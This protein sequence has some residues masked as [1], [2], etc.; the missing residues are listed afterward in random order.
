M[1]RVVIIPVYN[2]EKSLPFVLKDLLKLKLDEI[3]VVDNASSDESKKIILEHHVSYLYESR[4]GYGSACLKG[5]DYVYSKYQEDIS[6]GFIDGDYS[7]HPE[8]LLKLFSKI[9]DG[10]DFVLGSRLLGKSEKGALLIHAK[11]GNKFACFVM[12]LLYPRGYKFSDLGPMRVIKKSKLLKL[13]M[14]DTNFGWTIEMQLKALR[15]KLK[16]SELP[17][18]YKKRIGQSKI[19]GTLVGSLKASIKILYSLY[20]YSRK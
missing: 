8:D 7:D 1:K 14:V 16:I 10:Y 3:I 20:L 11:L 17:A 9:D 15:D 13:G 2:E 12:S 5:L 19:S 18:S 4:A 6:I